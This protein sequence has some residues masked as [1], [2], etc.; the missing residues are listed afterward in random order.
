LVRKGAIERRIDPYFY[1]YKFIKNQSLILNCKYKF[2]KFK[3]IIFEFSGEPMGFHLHTYDYK[4]AGVPILRISNLKEIY[5][6]KNDDFIFVSEEKHRELKSS[7]IK[8]N[9]MIFSKAGKVGEISI[10]PNYFGNTNLNQALSRIKLKDGYSVEYVVYYL[11][12]QIGKLQIN[13][14]GSGRA[15]QDDLKMSEIEDFKIILPPSEIQNEIVSKF[16]LAYASKKQK[17]AEAAALWASIDSYL[18]QE[19]GITLP[20]PSEKRT[21][22]YTPANKV[23]G[24]RFDPFYYQDYFDKLRCSFENGK[25]KILPLKAIASFQS[26]FAFNS[27]DYLDNSNCMLLTIKNIRKNTIDLS[28]TTFLPDG[29]YDKY[30]ACQVKNGD[31]LIAMTGATIGKVGIYESD[32]KSLLNQRNGIIRPTAISGIVNHVEFLLFIYLKYKAKKSKTYRK[33]TMPYF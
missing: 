21:F 26:G 33:L 18:L 1:T 22:F 10:V 12:S 11:K 32:K 6:N 30:S 27:A 3:D 28:S 16:E 4:D 14:F 25:Y 23:S 19:L 13:R 20:P 24:G 17:E 8:P 29:F 9:D 31:L 7:Q 15:V 5:L 2:V